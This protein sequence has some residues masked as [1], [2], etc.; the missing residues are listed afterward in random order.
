MEKSC[1]I[2]APKVSPRPLFIFGKL[3]RPLHAR[4]FFEKWDILIDDYQKFIFT[5]S[6][7]QVTQ[8]IWKFLRKIKDLRLVTS[9]FYVSKHVQKSDIKKSSPYFFFRTQS[10]LREK[11][12]GNKRG[13]ELVFSFSSGYETSFK[14]S[15]SSDVLPDKAWW[16][17]IKQFFN[18]SKN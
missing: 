7:V 17:N 15:F 16:Y 14:K 3:K 13:L 1:R 6:I 2:C 4:I 5:K 11:I 9:L 18:Y 10:L 12:M 8:F